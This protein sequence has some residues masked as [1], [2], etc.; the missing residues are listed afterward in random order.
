MT[1]R[2]KVRSATAEVGSPRPAALDTLLDLQ[3]T[4]IEYAREATLDHN[5]TTEIGRFDRAIFE[6]ALSVLHAVY[7]LAKEG[8]WETANAPVRQLFEL[9]V[10]MEHLNTYPDRE[11]AAIKFVQFGSLQE[12]LAEAGELDF[13]QTLGHMVSA[14]RLVRVRT[15][16]GSPAYA[17]FRRGSDAR[18][19]AKWAKSWHGK[20]L[21]QLC[22]QSPKELRKI[23]YRTLF[24]EWS[25]QAHG[26]PGALV[27]GIVS[28]V[29]PSR[30]YLH[31]DV[32]RTKSL[33]AMALV[34]FLELWVML[35][36]APRLAAPIH[37]EWLSSLNLLI[38]APRATGFRM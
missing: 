25:E 13:A 22:D 20:T 33:V 28:S 23:N 26:A 1:K 29:F 4:V 9:L 15:I 17:E 3:A 2:R 11:L 21:S 7:I 10:N 19:Q 16:L 30:P 12:A 27:R 37:Q 8:H 6:R 14:T 31:D 24:S 38:V 35:P 5:P 36:D 32:E 34:Q 18:G